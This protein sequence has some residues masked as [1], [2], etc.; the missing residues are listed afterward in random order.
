MRELVRLEAGTRL[1]RAGE[2]DVREVAIAFADLVDF[3]GLG[4]RL[5]PNELAEVAERFETLAFEALEPGVNVVKTIGDEVMLASADPPALVASVLALIASAEGSDLPRIRAGA[6]AG[7]ARHRAG[8]WYGRTVNLASRLTALAE[9][10]TVAGDPVDRRRDA[11]GRV[12]ARGRARGTRL[13]GAGR[14]R[15]RPPL[16]VALRR[17]AAPRPA[18]RRSRRRGTRSAP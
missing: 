5:A 13:R 11:G 10:G 9:P 14:S 2:P 4:D 8:D 12:G 18:T 6:A 16:S 7:P 17:P 15:S 1:A 3:T